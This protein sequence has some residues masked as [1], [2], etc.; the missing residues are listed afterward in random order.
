MCA[1]VNRADFTF[2]TGV[3]DHFPPVRHH[4]VRERDR[5]LKRQE[6]NELTYA[7][8]REIVRRRPLRQTIG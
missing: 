5:M 6:W 2:R 4:R 8:R 1:E 7:A 3:F